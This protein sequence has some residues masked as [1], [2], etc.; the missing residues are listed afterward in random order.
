MPLQEKKYERI[1]LFTTFVLAALVCFGFSK[2]AFAITFDPGTSWSE[3]FT[4]DS[5]ALSQKGEYISNVWD[6]YVDN[7]NKK[8]MHVSKVG[9]QHYPVM[10]SGLN[11]EP[12]QYQIEYQAWYGNNGLCKAFCALR[13]TTHPIY[14]DCRYDCAAIR[15][16]R[17][18]YC[19]RIYGGQSYQDCSGF[20]EDNENLTIVMG[21]GNTVI[22]DGNDKAPANESLATQANC[23]KICY[24]FRETG[25]QTYLCCTSNCDLNW[26]PDPSFSLEYSWLYLHAASFTFQSATITSTTTIPSVGFYAHQS[27][28]DILKFRIK[29]ACPNPYYTD[30]SSPYCYWNAAENT[31]QT[32]KKRQYKYYVIQN[33]ACVE[34]GGAWEYQWLSNCGTPTVT[35]EAKCY[36]SELREVI[37]TTNYGCSSGQCTTESPVITYNLIQDCGT[38][39]LTDQYRCLGNLL[40]RK[41]ILKGCDDR[42]DPLWQTWWDGSRWNTWTPLGNIITSG[43]GVT[44]MYSGH[45]DVFYKGKDNALW[46]RWYIDGTWYG[47]QSLG[48]QITSDPDAISW[49]ASNKIYVYAKGTDNKIY[50]IHYNGS[51]W[52]SWAS[53]GVTATSGPTVA[54]FGEGHLDV[55]FKG[56]DNALWHKWWDGTTWYGPQ[57]LGGQITSDPD[58]ISWANGR[59]DVFAKGV[60]NACYEEEVWIDE[61][62]CGECGPEWYPDGVCKEIQLQGICV[63]GESTCQNPTTCNTRN[64][65]DYTPCGCTVEADGLPY[66]NTKKECK[67]GSC[68]DSGICWE[69]CGASNECHGKKPG[70]KTDRGNYCDETCNATPNPPKWLESKPD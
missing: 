57:S 38:E 32:W 27:N 62:D 60:G 43:P 64:K 56:T 6:T 35:K 67:T 9:E 50:Q 54:S 17:P 1:I 29:K 15:E 21:N 42:N 51:S 23:P 37:T 65:P 10:L 46:H 19:G 36:G 31:W 4:A 24:K 11:L 28:I 18:A 34:Q 5:S 33:N 39:I 16:D 2:K 8:Y 13:E 58:A 49:P 59:I 26:C 61:E 22:P 41:K 20:G 12:G 68:G 55:F 63:D 7:N 40:Q 14:S 70:D 69:P 30:W 52:G 66:Y 25:P 45:L 44:S 47:P 48:G 53:L 3:W